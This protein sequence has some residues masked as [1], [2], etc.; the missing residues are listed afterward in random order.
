MR[1]ILM[2]RRRSQGPAEYEADPDA[3]KAKSRARSKAEYQ[4]DPDAKKTSG[5]R[6]YLN[7]VKR[8]HKNASFRAYY[9]KTREAIYRAQVGE[10]VWS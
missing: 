1:L 3:K 4:A 7:A 8:A 2:R 6:A 5:R 10:T 9:S